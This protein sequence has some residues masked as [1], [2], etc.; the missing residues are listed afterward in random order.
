ML[1]TVE[2]PLVSMDQDA[3]C[4]MGKGFLM[5][6]LIIPTAGNTAALRLPFI[7]SE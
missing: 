2:V 1:V 3:N 7:I 4:G 5:T 6:K